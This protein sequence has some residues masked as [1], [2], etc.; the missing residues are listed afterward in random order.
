[1]DDATANRTLGVQDSNSPYVLLF[2]S[3]GAMR[4][5]SSTVNR[6]IEVPRDRDAEFRASGSVNELL[7]LAAVQRQAF[8]ED[9]RA[10]D[11]YAPPAA[12]PLRTHPEQTATCLSVLI[13]VIEELAQHLGH[14]EITRDM[15]TAK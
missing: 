6:G 14:L 11:L 13:H 9:V 2:H 5:W 1:M 8:I 15:L 10:T 7:E 12:A 4:R 3:L